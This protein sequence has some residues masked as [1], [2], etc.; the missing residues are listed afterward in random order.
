MIFANKDFLFSKTKQLFTHKHSR[1]DT[2]NIVCV[3]KCWEC[4]FV[5]GNAECTAQLLLVDEDRNTAL[6][7]S[8]KV[9]QAVKSLRRVHLLFS[10]I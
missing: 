9:R 1:N 4:A 5:C 8:H 10:H 7:Q 6:N 2:E 3:E